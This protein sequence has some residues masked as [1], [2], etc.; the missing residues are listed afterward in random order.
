MDCSLP[1]SSGHQILQDRILSVQLL[2][3]LG[4]LPN[5]GNQTQASYIAGE[6]FTY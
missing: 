5:P 3:S 4:D 2:L 6:F 1:V